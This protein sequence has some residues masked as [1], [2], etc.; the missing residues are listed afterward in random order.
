MCL[1]TRLA[2]DTPQVIASWCEAEA[3][4]AFVQPSLPGTTM[5]STAAATTNG[6]QQY[7]FPADCVDAVLWHDIGDA[8]FNH[9]CAKFR[10]GARATAASVSVSVSL[11]LSLSLS[12]SVSFCLSSSFSYLLACLPLSLSLSL[13]LCTTVTPAMRML[14]AT[15]RALQRDLRELTDD[16]APPSA[17][18][19]T[20][21]AQRTT[22]SVWLAISGH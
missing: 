11:S 2:A 9:A 19:T 7:W 12:V 15:W 20:A 14:G 5:P 21:A 3:A 22:L 10:A 4:S 16:G 18:T 8:A 17:A 6:V 13:S 1:T